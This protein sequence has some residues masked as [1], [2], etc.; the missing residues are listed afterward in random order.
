M[1]QGTAHTDDSRNELLE[2][3]AAGQRLIVSEQRQIQKQLDRVETTVQDLN[4]R[5]D[6]I[7][8]RL[9]R[10]EQRRTGLGTTPTTPRRLLARVHL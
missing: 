7:E 1:V 9:K 10:F 5:I 6:G 4:R 3:L 8:R 2:A